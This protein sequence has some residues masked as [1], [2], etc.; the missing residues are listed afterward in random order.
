[1]SHW[2]KFD[3]ELL[4]KTKLDKLLP[5]FVKRG[6]DVVQ[7]FARAILEKSGRAANKAIPDGKPGQTPAP[8]DLSTSK[9]SVEN[10]RASEL[11]T[12]I[13]R[14]RPSDTPNTSPTK[15][16]ASSTNG[17]GNA[18]KQVSLFEKKRQQAAKLDPKVSGKPATN[19]SATEKVKTNHITA[20]PS[21]FFSSLQSASKKSN[22][23]KPG[24][25]GGKSKDKSETGKGNESTSTKPAYSFAA[26]MANLN[27]AK[28]DTPSK[29]EESGPPET[30][31]EKTKRLR[32]E[33]R[34]KLRVSFKADD[35]L[36]EVR[37]FEHDPEEELGHDDSM[38]RDVGDSRG[39]GQMLKMHQGLNLE[40][41]DDDYEPAEQLPATWSTPSSR[42][43]L[44]VSGSRINVAQEWISVS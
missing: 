23:S 14:P 1:M 28:T 25:A 33:Q 29:T 26:T 31:E 36:V 21:A 6:D 38:V 32:K 20:K 9:A 10:A 42:F 22:L 8:K 35:A 24:L 15:K 39:E 27:K 34:R 2:L 44:L 19:T 30:P 7:K 3:K 13:K 40:D 18:P 11:A 4:E 12:G 41:E 16:Q 37:T 17:V 5:R 43:C